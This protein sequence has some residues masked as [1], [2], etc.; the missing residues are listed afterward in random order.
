MCIAVPVEIIEIYENEALVNFIGVKK[1][2]NTS[3]IEDITLGDYVLLHAGCA[4]E[5][6]NKEEA[7]ETLRIFES[8]I[9][10]F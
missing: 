8:L 3:L 4:I 9:T 6:L 10:N 2:V 7:E 5:K 1:K